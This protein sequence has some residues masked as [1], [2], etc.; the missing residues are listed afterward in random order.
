[1]KKLILFT[2]G[3]CMLFLFAAQGNA[4]SAIDKTKLI[5]TWE[6]CD[7]LGNEMPVGPGIKEYKVITPESFTVLQASKEKGT[8]MG[9]F[10][11]SYSIENDTYIENLNYTIPQA[12]GAKGTKNLF[13]IVFKN[14]LMFIN[15]INNPY[16]QVWKKADLSAAVNQAPQ[17]TNVTS[18]FNQKPD[19]A[20]VKFEGGDGKTIENSI[21][22][23]ANNE[24]AG[25]AA[26]YAYISKNY[27]QKKVDWTLKSQS[28]ANQ[29]AK[30]YDVMSFQLT[31]NNEE[32]TL[33]FD[34]TGFYGKM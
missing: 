18:Y 28:T 26:E 4:Q 3:I 17:K 9:I 32:I 8:F 27:A 12:A 19:I 20:N 33:Y 30:I 7:S 2:L 29:N 15:G 21:I 10:F 1:M 13:Y 14:D 34:I 31:K 11:G 24:E 25:V 16:K 23:E 6:Q 22:I 5:G